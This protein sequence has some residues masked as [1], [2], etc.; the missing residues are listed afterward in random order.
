[1]SIPAEAFAEA[2][3]M[4]LPLG[5]LV[6]H[7]GNWHV[8]V[9]DD[10]KPTD[11]LVLEGA[12]KGRLFNV[13]SNMAKSFAV[14]AP[15]GWYPA[16]ESPQEATSEGNTTVA[17]TLTDQGIRIIGG[18]LD[19]G[20]VEYQAYRTDGTLDSAYSSYGLGLRFASWTVELF[21]SRRP[22]QSMGKLLSVTASEDT[23]R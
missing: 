11:L 9:G 5:S 7:R 6:R 20:D 16:I 15:F 13:N 12:D 17:L 10:N 8:L 23:K 1:M 4:A 3:A 21:H 19:H 14:V 18:R 2:Y 22:F